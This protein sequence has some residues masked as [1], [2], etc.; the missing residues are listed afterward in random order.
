MIIKSCAFNHKIFCYG[1]SEFRLMAVP[2]NSKVTLEFCLY[3]FSFFIN[4]QTTQR[5]I[6][7]RVLKYQFY[8][9]NLPILSVDLL[10]K[11]EASIYLI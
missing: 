2:M 6:V 5:I 8:R 11:F 1:Y 7:M 4:V 3:D 10:D 9:S